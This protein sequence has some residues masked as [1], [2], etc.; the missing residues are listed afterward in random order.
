MGRQ[1]VR[2]WRSFLFASGQLTSNSSVVRVATFVIIDGV[3]L[4]RPFPT[5]LHR[6]N[7]S[8][9]DSAV[10]NSETGLVHRGLSEVPLS[11]R[12]NPRQALV[13]IYAAQWGALAIE[14]ALSQFFLWKWKPD[15]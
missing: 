7:A 6:F 10:K 9:S 8:I 14:V 15:A 11:R 5:G 1:L 13:S 4:P 2:D 3:F 12:V